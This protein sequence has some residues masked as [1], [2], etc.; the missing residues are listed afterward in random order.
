MG[1]TNENKKETGI[2]R[3]LEF[4]ILIFRYV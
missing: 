3:E 1:D 4:I 2:T